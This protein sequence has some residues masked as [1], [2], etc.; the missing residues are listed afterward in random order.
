MMVT[1]GGQSLPASGFPHRTLFAGQPVTL[2]RNDGRAA[3]RGTV[4]A[5][6]EQW[7]VLDGGTAVVWAEQVDEIVIE[8]QQ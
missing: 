2:L 8:A 1:R 3:E 5:V 7:I 6:H 4:K